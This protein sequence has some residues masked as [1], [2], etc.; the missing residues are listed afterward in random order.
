MYV[1][2]VMPRNMEEIPQP[3]NV[4]T[5]KTWLFL[6]SIGFVDTLCNTKH[7]AVMDHRLFV[8]SNICAPLRLYKNDSNDS[9]LV[10]IFCRQHWGALRWMFDS[11][12]E[13]RSVWGDHRD[14]GSD[15]GRRS[16]SHSRCCSNP[17]GHLTN[18]CTYTHG[19]DVYQQTPYFQGNCNWLLGVFKC[20]SMFTN[21][22][23]K[24]IQC[25]DSPFSWK[26]QNTH[27]TCSSGLKK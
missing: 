5:V 2:S 23:T 3:T 20:C 21:S 25:S 19:E 1:R 24:K 27:W 16:W 22:V 7:K 10:V 8:Q 6:L 4:I 14:S 13:Q 9:L 12:G 11:P 18:A 15:W 17:P 26:S